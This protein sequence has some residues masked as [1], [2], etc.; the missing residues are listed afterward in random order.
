MQFLKTQNTDK[1]AKYLPHIYRKDQPSNIIKSFVKIEKTSTTKYKAPRMIQ[2]RNPYYTMSLGRYTIPLEHKIYNA[3][4]TRK[5]IFY[6]GYNLYEGATMIIKQWQK[7]KNPY[8]FCLD[9]T[10]F[11]AH[12]TEE[13]LRL[14]HKFILLHND[15]PELKQLLQGQI[16]NRSYTLFNQKFVWKAT[17]ASGDI[18]TSFYD[19]LINYY[20]LKSVLHKLGI[21]KFRIIVNGDDSII[22]IDKKDL[23]KIGNRKD[24]LSMFRS[25]NMETKIDIE[26]DDISKIEFCRMNLRQDNDKHPMMTMTAERQEKIYG[27][28]Y[29]LHNIDHNTYQRD[30]AYANMNIYKHTQRRETFE[31]LFMHYDRLTDTPIMH[32]FR[33]IEPLIYNLLLTTKRNNEPTPIEL[34]VVDSVKIRINQLTTQPPTYVDHIAKRVMSYAY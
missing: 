22:I 28:R 7:F 20:I 26:T 9:H 8:A 34:P 17:V 33:T 2:A 24:F 25:F 23:H 1:R 12:V 11:D 18:T 15:D 27:M 30:I 13:A 14:V 5:N 19:S 6:K 4:K 31:N 32:T 21:R 3:D 29:K 10:S 16:T